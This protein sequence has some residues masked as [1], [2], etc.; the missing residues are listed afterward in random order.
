MLQCLLKEVREAS[1][2][3]PAVITQLLEAL[4]PQHRQQL[5]DALTQLRQQQIQQ[6]KTLSEEPTTAAAA[7]V[8]VQQLQQLSAV[9]V[10]LMMSLQQQQSEADIAFPLMT[11]ILEAPR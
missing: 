2:L 4:K 3:C 5:S 1:G 6:E 9:D 11:G 8:L 7:E 10:L